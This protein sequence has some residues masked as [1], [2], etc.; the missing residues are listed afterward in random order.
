MD[1]DQVATCMRGPGI[2]AGLDRVTQR[3]VHQLVPADVAAGREAGLERRAHIVSTPTMALRAAGL[4]RPA[5]RSM[6]TRADRC[7]CVSMESGSSVASPRSRTATSAGAL[8]WMDSIVSPETTN[9][10]RAAH[11][12]GA[13]VSTRCASAHR[14]AIGTGDGDEDGRSSRAASS[15]GQGGNAKYAWDLRGR[16]NG[17]AGGVRDR[18]P[19]DKPGVQTSVSLK[20]RGRDTRRHVAETSPRDSSRHMGER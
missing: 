18:P 6:P 9:P 20:M 4:L 15:R 13:R 19:S 8:D 17:P 12:T 10:D 1:S 11:Q 5:M 3:H 7:V 16:G 14:E 2:L